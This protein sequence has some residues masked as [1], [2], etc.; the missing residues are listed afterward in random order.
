M[1]KRLIVNLLA[2]CALLV[3]ACSRD[4]TEFNRQQIVGKWVPVDKEVMCGYR[5]SADSSCEKDIG[6]FEYLDN[7]PYTFDRPEWTEQDGKTGFVLPLNQTIRYYRSNSSYMVN[8]DSL[9]IVDPALQGWSRRQIRFLTADT[10]VLSEGSL[11]T[12]VYYVREKPVETNPEPLF[13]Y[14]FIYYPPTGFTC[15]QYHILSRSG[16]YVNS[17]KMAWLLQGTI[18]EADYEKLEQLYQQANILEYLDSF[19][20]EESFSADEPAIIVIRNEQLYKLR[21]D[22]S[23]VPAE[24]A[25]KYYQAYVSTLFYPDNLYFRPDENI[26]YTNP[27]YHYLN[28]L[29]RTLRK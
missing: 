14:V 21:N 4:V 27:S 25:K 22:L 1:G 19:G 9:F 7:A 20:Y 3:T 2:G 18:R 24:N 8:E 5:F 17:N 12:P 28:S 15:E 6:F 26:D 10:L 16:Q 11:S 23:H 29:M 13:D